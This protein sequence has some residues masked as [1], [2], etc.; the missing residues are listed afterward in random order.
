VPSRAAEP[1]AFVV[2]VGSDR[3]ADL[4]VIPVPIAGVETTRH[5]GVNAVGL[6]DDGRPVVLDVEHM[7]GASRLSEGGGASRLAWLRAYAAGVVETPIPGVDPA[8]LHGPCDAATKAAGDA[9]GEFVAWKAQ[10]EPGKVSGPFG[11]GPATFLA[12]RCLHDALRGIAPG[13]AAPPRAPDAP[14]RQPVPLPPPTEP[15]KGAKDH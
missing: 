2:L 15:T 7:L 3:Y 4:P 13:G 12:L 6:M 14:P 1:R 10:E 9:A 5:E 8:L 11:H